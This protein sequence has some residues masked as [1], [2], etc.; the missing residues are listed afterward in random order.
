MENNVD[1]LWKFRYSFP[2]LKKIKEGIK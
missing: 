2:A 1:K